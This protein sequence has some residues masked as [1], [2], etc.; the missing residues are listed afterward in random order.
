M[1]K[2]NK[3]IRYGS[4][5]ITEQDIKAVIDVLQSDWLTQGPKVKEFEERFAEYIGAKYAV[6]VSNGTAAL[7]ISNLALGCK[8]GT[9][10]ITTPITFVASANATK[11]CG[12]EVYFVD[13]DPI[14]NLLDLQKVEELIDSHPKGFFHGIVPVDFAGYAVDLEKFR[15][16]A[17]KHGLWIIE[18]ACHAPGGYFIDQ[19]GVQQRCGNGKFADLAIFSFHPVKHIACGEG[20][21][22]TTNNFELYE[23]LLKLRSHGITSQDQDFQNRNEVAIGAQV[24]ADQLDSNKYPS[25][26]MEMQSLGYNYRLTDIQAALGISQLTAADR[27]IQRRHAIANRYSEAFKSLSD[28]IRLPNIPIGHALHLYIIRVNDRLGLYNY[29]RDHQIYTQ[30]HYFPVHKMPYYKSEL[31]NNEEKINAE[32]YYNECISLPI[33]P[34]LSEEDQNLIID[35]IVKFYE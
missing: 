9:R 22:V 28:K 15:A 31:R 6:A 3:V 13:I 20:G 12:G 21:M 8:A 26:Y 32:E 7:H 34:K 5:E 14:T 18:D 29:L 27:G 25:W 30:I 4:Q 35:L 19:N 24:V 10:V 33:Y 23:K 16:L 1:K 2:E 17:D 11:F